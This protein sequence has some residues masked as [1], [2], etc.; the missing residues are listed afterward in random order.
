MQ[1]DEI[2]TVLDN[3]F[4]SCATS[5]DVII[6]QG[7]EGDNFYIIEQVEHQNPYLFQYQAIQIIIMAMRLP[8]QV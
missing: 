1:E 2:S 6:N 7:D 3:L 8:R 4:P 5:G